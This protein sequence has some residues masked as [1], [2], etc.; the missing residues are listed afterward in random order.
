MSLRL[1]PAVSR[2]ERQVMT[3][4]NNAGQSQFFSDRDVDL[5]AYLLPGRHVSKSFN[6]KDRWDGASP[7]IAR[8]IRLVRG[9]PL[10][11]H[12]AVVGAFLLGLPREVADDFAGRLRSLGARLPQE[13]R[14][15][16]PASERI[17]TPR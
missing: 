10:E 6:Y 15:I 12:R 11:H 4:T 2:N 7:T 13:V 16:K 17:N 9:V 8:L 5:I 1:I 3:S 14:S